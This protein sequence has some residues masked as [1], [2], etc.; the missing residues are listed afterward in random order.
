[1]KLDVFTAPPR[2]G[3]NGLRPIGLPAPS[4][5]MSRSEFLVINVGLRV[6]IRLPPAL[7]H[8]RTRLPRSVGRLASTCGYHCPLGGS[9]LPGCGCPYA[10]HLGCLPSGSIG[11][12]RSLQVMIFV[13][14]FLLFV[15]RPRRSGPFLRSPGSS[16][17]GKGLSEA[18]RSGLKIEEKR[19][20]ASLL[21]AAGGASGTA[22]RLWFGQDGSR[23][24]IG[25][26]GRPS[27]YED[28]LPVQREADTSGPGM[29]TEKTNGDPAPPAT[30]SFS[31]ARN[32]TSS[33]QK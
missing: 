2:I 1:M 5:S 14:R 31:P 28:A 13:I 6:R 30:T 22:S 3:R 12:A 33:V 25:I 15:A 26:N 32:R 29:D 9:G 16:S 24:Q 21:R 4:N 10:G 18:A 19:E 17:S 20:K 11:A 23:D 8:V 27:E 7:S